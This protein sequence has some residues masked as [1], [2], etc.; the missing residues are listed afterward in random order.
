[1][2]KL[3]LLAYACV[4]FAPACKKDKDKPAPADQSKPGEELVQ[5]VNDEVSGIDSLSSFATY[6]KDLQLSDAEAA[7]GITVFAPVNS[8]FENPEGRQAPSHAGGLREKLPDSSDLEDYIVKGILT[9]GGLT[10]GKE[11]ATLSGKTLT[12]S[13]KDGQLYLNN[14]LISGKNVASGE[15]YTLFTLSGL[16]R[17]DELPAITGISDAK[18]F[19]GW[20]LTIEGRNF[21]TSPSDNEVEFNGVKAVVHTASADKLLVTVP[22]GA[23]TGKITVH[24]KGRT[25]TSKEDVTIMQ[26]KVSTIDA[27]LSLNCGNIQ[28]I[29]IDKNDNL[30]FTDDQNYRVIGYSHTGQITVYQPVVQSTTD[31]NMDGIVNQDDQ[32]AVLASPWGIAIDAQGQVYVSTST[33]EKGAIYKIDPAVPDQAEL[34]AGGNANNAPLEGPKL[35]IQV[36]PTMLQFD[37]SGNLVF[38]DH[39]SGGDILQRVM[40][41]GT[42]SSLFPQNSFRSVDPTVQNDASIYGIAFDDDNNIYI[43]DAGNARIWKLGSAGIET[44]AG[45]TNNT[46]KDGTG[47]AAQFGAPFGI[48]RDKKGNLYVCDNDYTN[49]T[50]LIR[51]INPQ[52]VVTTIAGGKN[53]NTES[54]D[55]PGPSARFNGVNTIGI[56]SKG[57][58]YIGTDDGR[59]RK[60]S[61]E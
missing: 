19:P 6:L 59:I 46:A 44:L 35:S 25:V 26:A 42:V 54:T 18:T 23:T 58:L 52:G 61:I 33:S 29:A 53:S 41:N 4:L 49:T 17:R 8:A 56:D 50:Y 32:V 10:D 34:W 16:I 13:I 45:N 22:Q 21:G 2:K 47:T 60:L 14:I 57:V 37:N 39:I 24:V 20:L 55:G 51:M 36:S 5:S 15:N 28:G 9:I 31:V 30:Y 48:A 40:P 43:G 11:L 27:L 38:N 12:V 7:A 3:L 1:M